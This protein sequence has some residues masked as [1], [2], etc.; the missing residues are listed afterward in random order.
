M[1]KSCFIY[2]IALL[3]LSISAIAQ[4]DCRTWRWK[5]PLPQGN[6]LNDIHFTDSLTG[7]AVG[8]LGIILKTEDAGVTW[9][10]LS[11]GTTNVLFAVTFTDAVTGYAVGDSGTILKTTDAGAT[12]N[13]HFSE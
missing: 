9:K 8:R 5:N 12:W 4:D 10:P 2:V 7:Y 11:S 13:R 1:N 3:C 6:T